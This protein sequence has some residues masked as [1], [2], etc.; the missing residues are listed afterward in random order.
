MTD[1]KS[2][3]PLSGG[4]L[5]LLLLGA[6][7]ATT[8]PNEIQ[9]PGTQPG[10]VGALP[11]SQACVTC[12]A[13][14]SPV[15]EPYQNWSGSP[16]AHSGRDPLF[17][18]AL[19]IAEQDFDGSGDHCL[20]CHAPLG[21]I[22]GNSTP[23]DGSALTPDDYDGVSCG[24][25]HA[26]TN[27]DES[28]HVGVQVAPFLAHDGGTPKEGWYG[29]GMYVLW[30]GTER[31]GPYSNAIAPHGT[32]ESDFHRD[33]AM[34]G[35]CH[36]VS[37]PLTGDLAHN[38]GAHAPLP[39]GSFSGV[40]G[41][42]VDQKAAFNNAP[43]SYG[44]VERTFSEHVATEL[45][46]LQVSQYNELPGDLKRGSIRRAFQQ[47]M[48][49]T[50]DGNYVDGDTRL[51]SCQ[52]CHMAPT[53]GIGCNFGAPPTRTDLPTHDLTGANTWIGDALTW[54]HFQLRLQGGPPLDGDQ[55]T[56][57]QE[58]KLRARDNLRNS[59]AIQ[60]TGDQVTVTNL[61][62]HKLPSG[63]PEGRR[64]WLRTTWYDATDTV[65]RIDG[66]YGS[67]NAR[68]NGQVTPVD[69]ILD[70]TDPNLHIYKTEPAITQAWAQQLIGFGTAGTTPLAY[71]RQSG[72]VT[73]TL[74]DVAAQAPG[75]SFPTQHFI[76]NNTVVSDNR[77]PPYRMDRD[78]AVER[79]A[80]P[81]PDTLYGNPGAGG[82]YDHADS[83]TLNPP[84]TAVRADLELLYQPTSWEYVQF[85]YE[86]N[87]GSNTFL[88]N[89]GLNVLDA[90]LN[91]GMA[92]P[93]VMAEARWGNNSPTTYCTAKV[94]SL[95]CTPSLVASGAPRISDTEGFDLVATNLR[96]KKAGIVFYGVNGPAA[97][98]FQAGFLCVAPPIRRTPLQTSGGSPTGN[99]CTGS[100]TFDMNAWAA[101]GNDPLLTAGQTVNAQV[102]SRDPGFAPPNNTS[103]TDAV[104]FTFEP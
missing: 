25:C 83:F 23:T 16:M 67:I 5:I 36:D 62:G 17:W 63:Y 60:V 100:I 33:S 69:T 31:L 4:L 6:S 3:V 84:A 66:E 48:A 92:A 34:C 7:L 64:M 88:Q 38:N 91:T 46:A 102:W 76:L 90:W 86:G 51:F 74:A 14:F 59:A 65:V 78:T 72:A 73:K 89:A 11:T 42:P 79:N 35:T 54:L 101:G 37:N 24:L 1:R 2:L 8:V 18:A 103:L 70:P 28:E 9:M 30:G 94:N 104:E 39:P 15:V 32:M 12:H 97:I 55:L 80:Q 98:P 82:H 22:A 20:R 81:I 75:T 52:T 96:N 57:L 93:E 53:T 26:M 85:L 58:G 40:L 13:G 45:S 99:D 50:S 95:G 71:D 41:S 44:V 29:S 56:A 10:D 68:I 19:A 61:T 49:S 27:P 77:I 43:H 87:D 21:W 47:A